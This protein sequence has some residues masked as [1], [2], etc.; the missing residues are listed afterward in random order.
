MTEIDE[1]QPLNMQ[2]IFKGHSLV[3]ARRFSLA[4]EKS[5]DGSNFTKICKNTNST[6][7]FSFR[8]SAFLYLVAVMSYETWKTSNFD[9]T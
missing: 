1:E 3:S 7:I 4:R 2:T 6:L 9:W 8:L 5:V